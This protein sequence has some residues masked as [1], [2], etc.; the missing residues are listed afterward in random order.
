MRCKF[1]VILLLIATPLV[2]A[3]KLVETPIKDFNSISGKWIGWGYLNSGGRV[4]Y[5]YI[6]NQLTRTGLLSPIFPT[7]TAGR[8]FKVKPAKKKRNK[9]KKKKNQTSEKKEY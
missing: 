4:S 9:K 7:R 2:M 8:T 6:I 1:E 3:A 5:S